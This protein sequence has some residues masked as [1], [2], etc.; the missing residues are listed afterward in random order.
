MKSKYPL[1]ALYEKDHHNKGSDSTYLANFFKSTLGVSN[2]CQEIFIEELEHLRDN[3]QDDFDDIENIYR[4]LDQIQNL[5]S[6]YL[7][8]RNPPVNRKA[9]R[10]GVDRPPAPDGSRPSS[11]FFGYNPG[12]SHTPSPVVSLFGGGQP[13]F[14]GGQPLSGLPNTDSVGGTVQSAFK[15]PES[16]AI[17]SIFASKS[18]A[19]SPPIFGQYSGASA[20][21]SADS[22]G[23]SSQSPRS[24]GLSGI[25]GSKRTT[26]S[27]STS[28][29]G[30]FGSSGTTAKSLFGAFG[31]KSASSHFDSRANSGFPL[32]SSNSGSNATGLESLQ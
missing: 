2:A 7:G 12:S 4:E 24:H 14:G 26:S 25:F 21:S 27:P 31:E 23:Q 22:N 11:V 6:K 28:D 8:V 20:V 16:H 15:S 13:L 3:K 5:T 17:P 32:G 29:F 9:K 19:P 18:T 30:V 1:A 10:S